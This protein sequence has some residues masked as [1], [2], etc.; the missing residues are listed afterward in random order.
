MPTISVLIPTHNCAT[1]LPSAVESALAQTYLDIEVIVVDDGS[2]DETAAV[3]APYLH[4]I[5]YIKQKNAGVCVA[6]NTAVRAAKGEF[7]AWLDA[8]D[9]WKP[10]KLELQMPKFAD[11]SIGIVYSDFETLYSDGHFRE[12]FLRNHPCVCEGSV[13]EEYVQSRFFLPSTVVM[14]SKCFTESGLFDEEM[15]CSGDVELFTRICLRWK[16]ALVNRVLTLRN[17]GPYNITADKK[18]VG[19][20]MVL[21]LN[22]LLV[23]TRELSRS[24][25]RA[26]YNE[27]AKQHWHLGYE[28]FSTGEMREARRHLRKVIRYSRS[29]CRPCVLLIA[30]SYLPASANSSLRKAK[31]RIQR[32]RQNNQAQRNPEALA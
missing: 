16:V 31:A 21:A 25:R 26:V 10:D 12:S 22:K 24:Q 29:R 27:L 30:L 11:S 18:R 32:T 3:L 1:F 17:E 8:D 9:S 28:A 6:R 23:K 19:T 4:H 14:R 13:F 15:R 5:T 2:T 7:I 20:Y